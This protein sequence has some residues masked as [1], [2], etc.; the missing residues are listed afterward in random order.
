M[1]PPTQGRLGG[2]PSL[3][4]VERQADM[5]LES[6][7]VGEARTEIVLHKMT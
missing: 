5:S 1:L 7:T 2:T 4:P 3:L 6:G